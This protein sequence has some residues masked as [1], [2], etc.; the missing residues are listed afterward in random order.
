MR[1]LCAPRSLSIHPRCP[2]HGNSAT[3]TERARYGM[4]P[5]PH[6][7]PTFGGECARPECNEACQRVRPAAGVA[8]PDHQTAPAADRLRTALSAPGVERLRDFY[9]VGP[10]QRAAVESFADALAAVP[11]EATNMEKN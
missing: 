1:C 7:C 2:I 9:A 5:R 11:A 3:N 4:P 6:F 8:A 10:V